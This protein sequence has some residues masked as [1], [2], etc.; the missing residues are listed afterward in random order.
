MDMHMF[1]SHKYRMQRRL[2]YTTVHNPGNCLLVRSTHSGDLNENYKALILSSVY[3]R[4]TVSN[5]Y[6]RSTIVAVYT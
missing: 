2:G 6:L 3:M 1:S 4:A 5:S